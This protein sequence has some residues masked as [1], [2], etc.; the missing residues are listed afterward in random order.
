M[1]DFGCLMNQARVE[2]ACLLG[3]AFRVYRPDFTVVDQTPAFLF[4]RNF[5]LS[6][7]GAKFTITRFPGIDFYMATG[8][9]TG[10]RF[11][12]ILIPV[13]PNSQWPITTILNFSPTNP[14]VV[15]RTSRLCSIK[16]NLN[17]SLY[18]NTY[19]DF[20]YPN[21]F[22]SGML[23]QLS[24]MTGTTTKRIVIWSR[25]NI[26]DQNAVDAGG[27]PLSMEGLIL[28][29]ED[30]LNPVRL[31]LRNTQTIGNLM[32]ADTVEDINN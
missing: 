8:D 32:I 28:E 27:N 13:D 12:D 14:M 30:G 11:G 21:Y 5:N 4:Q 10:L 1:L 29:A 22:E 23:K 7:G 9:R 19:F 3:E 26:Q 25:K 16:T 18:T 2:I 24:T 6:V 17:T 31:L 20:M 15:F